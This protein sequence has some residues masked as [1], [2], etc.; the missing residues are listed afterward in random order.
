MI[1]KGLELKQKEYDTKSAGRIDLLCIDRNGDF[2]VVETK[3]G[4]E[5]D[6]VVG[7]IQRYMGW[8]TRNLAKNG[9]NVRGIIIVNE[10]DEWLDYAVSVND[11]IQLKYYEVKFVVRYTAPN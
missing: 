10:F 7:Q 5:S 2:V 3:K 1:E 4:K 9:E 8:I 11:N 6:K